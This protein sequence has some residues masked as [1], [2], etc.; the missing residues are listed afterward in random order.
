MSSIESMVYDTT[1]HNGLRVIVVSNMKAPV[2]NITV[3]YKVGSK[4]DN[5]KHKGFA[6]FF[7]HLMFD[8]SLNVGR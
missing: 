6:H 5:I 4:D 8:G 1:L 2:V 7:E 3:G